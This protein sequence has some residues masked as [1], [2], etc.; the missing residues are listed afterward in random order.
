MVKEVGVASVATVEVLLIFSHFVVSLKFG[1]LRYS[2]LI[3]HP[4]ICPCSQGLY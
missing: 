4:G 2:G 1:S 3:F